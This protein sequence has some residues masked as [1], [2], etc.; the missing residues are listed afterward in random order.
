MFTYTFTNTAS[1]RKYFNITDDMPVDKATDI[2]KEFFLDSG[3]DMDVWLSAGG[4]VIGNAGSSCFLPLFNEI[5][6][7]IE[8]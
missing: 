3:L 7:E 4:W 8:A 5:V 2:V 6:E 1:F